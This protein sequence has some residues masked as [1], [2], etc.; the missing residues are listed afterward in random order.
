VEVIGSSVRAGARVQLGA[1]RVSG[2]ILDRVKRR[3][4]D[5]GVKPPDAVHHT[6]FGLAEPRAHSVDPFGSFL[7]G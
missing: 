4:R 6:G 2:A 7:R 1:F 5:L 3:L